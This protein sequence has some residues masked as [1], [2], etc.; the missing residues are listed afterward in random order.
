[1]KMTIEMDNEQ[2]GARPGGI[3][4]G[5]QP[6]TF[7]VHFVIIIDF[8]QI[9]VIGLIGVIGVIGVIAS[10]RVDYT[11]QYQYTYFV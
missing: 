7:G 8:D 11:V 1:M 2:V 9:G 5:Y 10:I 3:A 6:V 4:T